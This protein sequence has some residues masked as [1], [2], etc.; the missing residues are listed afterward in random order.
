MKE[1]VTD[2]LFVGKLKII[3]NYQTIIKSKGI[4]KGI[5]IARDPDGQI[6]Q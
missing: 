1:S 3:C 4:K 5:I 6:C 2:Q